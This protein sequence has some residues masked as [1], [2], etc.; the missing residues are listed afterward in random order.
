MITVNS[1]TVN[2][3]VG[4]WLCSDAISSAVVQVKS[5]HQ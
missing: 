5:W 3:P 4:D 1:V 2:V